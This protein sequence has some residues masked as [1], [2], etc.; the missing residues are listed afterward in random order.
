VAGSG[1]LMGSLRSLWIAVPMVGLLELFGHLYFARRAPSLDAWAS[2]RQPVSELYQPGAP[3]VVEPY[4]AEPLARHVLGNEMMPM[5]EVA[6]PDL[7]AY[8]RAVEVSLFGGASPEL[9]GW[10]TREERSV[11]PFAVRLR[12]NPAPAEV[13]FDFVDGLAP[14]QVSVEIDDGRPCPYR[15]HA[16]PMT[17]GLHGHI[18]FPAQRFECPGGPFF[19]VG[20]TVVDDERYRP[21]RCIWAHPSGKGPLRI[22]YR[23]V[24]LGDVI[25]GY[26][27]LSWFLMRD[28]QGTPIEMTVRIGGELTGAFVHRDEQGWNEF[29]LP[30]G[31]HAGTTAEVDFE[32]SSQRA[33]DRHF[34]FYADTR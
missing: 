32:I 3:V 14:D 8:A 18:A 12:E 1:L 4:W 5:R 2:I 15:P 31:S 30:T 27:A 19:F 34:C 6:R 10:N 28:G 20:V 21:R 24:A 25:R 29:E 26:G 11:G 16:R 22:R 7:S 33:K 13:R 9:A 23:S 17:G